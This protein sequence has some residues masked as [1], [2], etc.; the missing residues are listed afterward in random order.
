MRL[1][2]ATMGLIAVSGGLF[3][4]YRAVTFSAGHDYVLTV[5]ATIAC[6]AAFR[7]GVELLASET[8][9]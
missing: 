2:R 5:C 4:A 1:L 3:F 6:V 7:A 9:E 8:A